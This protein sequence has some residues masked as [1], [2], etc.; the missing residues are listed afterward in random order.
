VDGGGGG[1]ERGS[2]VTMGKKKEIGAHARDTW[3]YSMLVNR[4]YS[5]LRVV[6]D[7]S[8]VGG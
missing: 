2:M 5:I 7:L 4:Y 3:W 6:R 8:T 1:I